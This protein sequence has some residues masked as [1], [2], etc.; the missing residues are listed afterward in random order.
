MKNVYVIVGQSTSCNGNIIHWIDAVY[1]NKQ[2]AFD[3]CDEMNQATQRHDPN[4]MAYVSGPILLD[5]ME[6]LV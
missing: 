6:E 1:V 5:E 3:V 2:K 4:Y